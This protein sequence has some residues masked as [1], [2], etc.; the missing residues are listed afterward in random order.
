MIFRLLVTR[1]LW[2][3]LKRRGASAVLSILSVAIG[4][5]VAAVALSIVR[6][7]MLR[8]LAY[9]RADEI[10]ELKRSNKFLGNR[11]F[12]Y[13]FFYTV[14]ERIPGLRS[15]A[16]LN[17][18]DMTLQSRVGDT[19][20]ERVTTLACSASLFQVLSVRPILGRLF[21]ASE[22][23][24][25]AGAAVAL[26]SEELWRGRFGGDPGVV[27][28]TVWLNGRAFQVIGV[29]PQ[30]LR[31]PPLPSP[32]SVWIPLGADPTLDQLEKMLP[33]KWAQ[34]IY[35]RLWARVDPR[36]S[37]A[38]AES[39]IR[40]VSA[41]VLALEDPTDHDTSPIQIARLEEIVRQR[42]RGEMYVL[43][44][45]AFL[46]LFISCAN[47]Y[48]LALSRAL[49]RQGEM[50]IRRA[51][52]ERGVHA[53]ARVLL[54]GVV[55]ATAGAIVGL[56]A[57]PSL[58]RCLEV[59]LPA[60]VLPF[61]SVGVSAGV[62][63]LVAVV[64]VVIVA[65]ALVPAAIVLA[66]ESLGE[67][68]SASR[69]ATSARPASRH[70]SMLVVLQAACAVVSLA[71]LLSLFRAYRD[72][73]KVPLGFDPNSVVVA[74][75]TLPEGGGSADEWRRLAST[76]ESE[77]QTGPR[78]ENIAV[79]IALPTRKT[80][81]PT[82]R[83]LGGSSDG[84]RGLAEYR[85]VSAGYFAA[86]RIPLISGRP[87]RSSDVEPVCVVSRGLARSAFPNRDAIGEHIEPAAGKQ[88]RIIGVAGDVVSSDLRAEPVPTIYIPF[89]QTPN[90]AI[91]SWLAVIG[92]VRPAPTTSGSRADQ[93][94]FAQTLHGVA[95]TLPITISALQTITDN[96]SA[97][98]KFHADLMIAVALAALVLLAAGAYG[99]A[100]T[101]VASRHRELATRAA[102]GATTER[103]ISLVVLESLR[104][105][106]VGAVV[107]WIA[108]VAILATLRTQMRYV[109]TA[110]PISFVGVSAAIV[111]LLV[112]FSYMPS[113]AIGRIAPASALREG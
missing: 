51:L 113:R 74:E 87:F 17:S 70:R 25:H 106:L 50:S 98:E 5:A 112:V 80:M 55:L 95:P 41:P 79:A 48:G 62:L 33:S 14:Q 93:Y 67:I 77:L 27:G 8:P 64:P 40:S 75:L 111:G 23:P 36:A 105:G 109:P 45:V 32:P 47:T 37:Q 9:A 68:G 11:P 73:S 24:R 86:L 35:L 71:I 56:I 83:V 38:Q 54:D 107:G 94:A 26:L 44:A 12:T 30:T 16:A 18:V 88:C 96:L 59:A 110:G 108:T 52:G 19:D 13:K 21:D 53:V 58:L 92:R 72:V 91:Q 57:T 6:T 101:Y 43:F 61:R 99:I 7:T 31:I 85:P 3:S 28:R 103:L 104:L 78:F 81:R 82:Y 29:T 15:L 89:W 49:P 100:S 65:A 46:A 84:A 4:V 102:L 2:R 63:S 34:S 76:M 69:R 97:D 66:Q 10:V 42:Y 90:E 60:G 22:E 1:D 39:A 20:P